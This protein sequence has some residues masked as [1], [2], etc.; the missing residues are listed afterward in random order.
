MIRQMYSLS[1]VRDIRNANVASIHTI[2]N[3][4]IPQNSGNSCVF[5][6]DFSVSM[7]D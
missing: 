7:L 2:T 1:K 4:T 6:K 5:D 3:I